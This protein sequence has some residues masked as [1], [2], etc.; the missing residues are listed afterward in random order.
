M[1]QTNTQQERDYQ[2]ESAWEN[3]K[4][5]IGDMFTAAGV[6][7]KSTSVGEWVFDKYENIFGDKE[8]HNHF[9]E[10]DFDFVDDDSMQSETQ[11]E[12]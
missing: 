8:D 11:C 6:W 2:K 9:K 1:S 3:L 12:C 4:D 10:S 7:F 5:S